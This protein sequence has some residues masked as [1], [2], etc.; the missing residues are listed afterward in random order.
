VMQ[1]VAALGLPQRVMPLVAGQSIS[2]D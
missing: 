1:G 2:I